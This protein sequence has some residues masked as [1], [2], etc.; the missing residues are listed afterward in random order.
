[1]LLTRIKGSKDIKD[2]RR[3]ASGGEKGKKAARY[4]QKKAMEYFGRMMRGPKHTVLQNIMIR[5]VEGKRR[6]G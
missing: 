2:N 5:K 3:S 1:M 4:C 6:I